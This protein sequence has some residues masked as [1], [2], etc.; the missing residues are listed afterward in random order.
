MKKL[1][2]LLLIIGIMIF[3][4]NC[5]DNNDDDDQTTA[6][7]LLALA[8]QQGGGGA[9]TNA[10]TATVATTS[11]KAAATTNTVAS[12]TSSVTSSTNISGG[13]TPTAKNVNS[14]GA[15]D[16]MEI[17]KNGMDP[18][19]LQKSL[20]ALIGEPAKANTRAV[21]YTQSDTD[22]N[23]NKTYTFSGTLTGK[24]YS[25]DKYITNYSLLVDGGK[26]I[27]LKI[28][29]FSS[30]T[31]SSSGS[32]TCS[33]IADK[34]TATISNGKYSYPSY[35]SSTSYTYKSEASVKFSDYG[36]F[37]MDPYAN[38]K[39]LKTAMDTQYFSKCSKYSSSYSNTGYTQDFSSSTGCSCSIITPIYKNFT[40]GYAA[41][42]INGDL[43]YSWESTYTPS[44]T[45]GTTNSDGSYTYNYKGSSKG[46]SNSDTGL[47]IVQN[48]TNS[49]AMT[50]SNLQ[51]QTDYDYTTTSKSTYTQ[52]SDGSYSYQYTI[53]KMSGS[54]TVKISGTV[55]GSAINETLTTTF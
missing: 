4:T 53:Y 27:D 28:P 44:Y 47:T 14:H 2:N 16:M 34:G 12:V 40:E 43:T 29:S 42:V 30:C 33:T 55:N 21:T 10:E 23:G 46:I 1:I 9:I 54:Y 36:T 26:C 51:Y 38:V 32:S 25:N 15:I 45:S 37:Y 39:A 52:N 18:V 35:T 5:Q 24:D 19:V 48:G 11:G 41:S 13:T 49:G 3:A 7:A 22:A 8:S 17:Y 6:I 50:F 31:T 20:K